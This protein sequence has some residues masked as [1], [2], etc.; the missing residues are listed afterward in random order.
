MSSP[1]AMSLM[2][3]ILSILSALAAQN[4]ASQAER[5]SINQSWYH[6][7]RDCRTAF[8]DVRNYLL[9]VATELNRVNKLDML[10]YQTIEAQISRYGDELDALEKD[11]SNN[12]YLNKEDI[13]FRVSRMDYHNDRITK[14]INKL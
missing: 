14:L 1:E 2:S 4:A 10:Q 12:R 13:S 9:H 11:L 8:V 7:Y 6:R 3:L 5:S